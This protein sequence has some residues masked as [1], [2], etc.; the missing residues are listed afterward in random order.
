MKSKGIIIG[1]LLTLALVV[2][3]FTFAFWASI[4]LED[5]NTEATVTIGEGRTATVTTSLTAT[6]AGELVPA[7]ELD[8]S[9]NPNPVE[10]IVFTFEVNWND[11]STLLQGVTSDI[12]IEVENISNATA[13]TLLNFDIS[14][15]PLTAEITQGTPLT[16]TITVTLDEPADQTA[17]DAIINDGVTFDVIFTV[18]DPA[19]Q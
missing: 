4:D 14:P 13:A 11:D 9:S 16:V 12:N 18:T 3:S 6:G 7:G 8:N 19:S 10:E 2:S 17:Y 1:T 5:T 15:D